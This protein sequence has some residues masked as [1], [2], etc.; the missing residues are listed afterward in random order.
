MKTTGLEILLKEHENM[1]SGGHESYYDVDK[2][3]EYVMSTMLGRVKRELKDYRS[4][5]E[6]FWKHDFDGIRMGNI[7]NFSRLPEHIRSR[8]FKDLAKKLRDEGLRVEKSFNN[9]V[10]SVSI[11]RYTGKNPIAKCL[12]RVTDIIECL[13]F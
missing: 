5:Q 3:Y 4:G 11:P 2:M 1:E 6:V 10:L 9:D 7:T 13:L 8:A 12:F